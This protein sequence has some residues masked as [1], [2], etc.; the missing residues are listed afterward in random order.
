MEAKRVSRSKERTTMS[1]TTQ[2]SPKVR[3]EKYLLFG[4]QLSHWRPHQEQLQGS[5][6]VNQIV[7][8]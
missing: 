8:G 2:M 7:A 3:T 5:R 4:E 6:G 1:N